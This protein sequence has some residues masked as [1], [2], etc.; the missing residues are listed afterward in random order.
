MSNY[1]RH[2]YGPGSIAAMPSG[3]GLTRPPTIGSNDRP[4]Q[5]PGLHGGCMGCM[6]DNGNGNGNGNGAAQAGLGAVVPILV[7]VAIGAAAYY[8]FFHRR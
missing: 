3:Y 2:Y 1:M 7:P 4:Q 5:I 8:L 6:G